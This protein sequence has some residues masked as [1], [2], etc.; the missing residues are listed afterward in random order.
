MDQAV[1]DTFRIYISRIINGVLWATDKKYGP[2]TNKFG[3]GYIWMKSI[4]LKTLGMR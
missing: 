3:R 4:I 2:S 1:A